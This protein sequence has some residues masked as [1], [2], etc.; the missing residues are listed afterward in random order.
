[1]NAEYN[2]NNGFQLL[3]KYRSALM[4]LSAL[5]IL[6]YHSGL[7]LIEEPSNPAI[8]LLYSLER[9]I[10]RI[11][12]C[13]VDIF[14]LV[15]GIGL[16]FAIKKG[17]LSTFYLHRIRRLL[18]A[19]ITI[20]VIR[21]FI[22]RW[23]ILDFLGN[24]SGFNFYFHHIYSFLW[25]VPA[26]ATL[27]LVF[28]LYY[29]LFLLAKN[30]YIFTAVTILIW[31]V[32]SSVFQ[33]LIRIDLYAFTNRIPIFVVGVLFGYLTQNKKQLVFKKITYLILSVLLIYGLILAYVYNFRSIK[34]LI[35][36]G[37]C[38][39]PNFLI[40]ISF[41]FLFSKL[42]D[43]F[44]QR[45]PKFEKGIVAVL[46]F[47]GAFSLELYCVQDM[48]LFAIPVLEHFKWPNP[49]INLTFF[50]FISAFSWF[51]SVVFKWVW[52]LTEKISKQKNKEADT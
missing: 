52:R 1:M 40:A 20:A 39:L 45:I 22:E 42:L 12:F 51:L 35:P 36:Q 24:V 4:G 11:G 18:P 3:T 6:Y 48:L 21:S 27:Y 25:F 23:T 38:F 46:S 8:H 7:P 9:Y 31:L 29:K 10:N 19:F 5:W 41:P 2:S 33:S 17:S 28:P 43:I 26:I 49:L 30:K 44:H 37:N 32:I 34:I 50:V 47:F 16:T 14:L 15:S 13:G